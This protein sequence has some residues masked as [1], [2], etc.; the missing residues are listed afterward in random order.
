MKRV[1]LVLCVAVVVFVAW[2][3]AGRLSSDAIGMAIGLAFGVLA[4]LPAAALVLLAGRRGDRESSVPGADMARSGQPGV[5]QAFGSP[6]MPIVVLALPHYSPGGQPVDFGSRQSDLARAPALP[7][8][9]APA[10]QR[11]F[12]I[13]GETDQSVDEW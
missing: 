1:V 3:V 11:S 10:G 12:R 5:G 8:P 9:V 2:R 13:V 7:G 6:Q 4:G